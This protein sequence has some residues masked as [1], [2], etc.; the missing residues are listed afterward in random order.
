MKL[1]GHFRNYH[2]GDAAIAPG[3]VPK[4]G[5]TMKHP[6]KTSAVGL[7]L[8]IEAISC[9]AMT[10]G[11]ARGAVV[12][13]QPLDITVPVQ[14]D[15]GEDIFSLCLD[16]DVFYGDAQQAKGRITLTSALPA[17]GQSGTVRVRSSQPVDE[18]V[19]AVSLRAGCPQKVSR[20]FTF[21]ADLPS[22]AV[23]L[24]KITPVPPGPVVT[25]ASAGKTAVI[26]DS[27][28]RRPDT[29]ATPPVVGN[30]K[31]ANTSS[32][33]P[34]PAVKPLVAAAKVMPKL[35]LAS[36]IPGDLRDPDLK[37]TNELFTLPVDN[38]KSAAAAIA[39]WRA[40]N[41]QP[42]DIMRDWQRLQALDADV[43]ALRVATARNESS[44]AEMKQ[45]LQ[46]AESERF[47]NGL[48]YGL[49]GLLLASLAGLFLLW[50]RRKG[51]VGASNS[52]WQGVGASPT[53]QQSG[54]GEIASTRATLSAAGELP[55]QTAFVDIDLDL[56]FA[57][58]AA[59]P[60]KPVPT[61]TDSQVI[62]LERVTS[63]SPPT[64][65]T[66]DRGFST[67]M[68][69][70]L[71]TTNSEEVV[72]VR[73]QADFF[74]SLGQYEQAIHTLMDRTEGAADVSPLVYLDLMQLLHRL[75]RRIDFNQTR[76]KFNRLFTGRVPEYATFDE[77]GKVLE[78]Y[79]EVLAHISSEWSSD[80]ILD[81]LEGCI[82]RVP[83]DDL[84]QPFDLAAFEDLLMLH[85]IATRLASDSH[86]G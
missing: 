58:S 68:V 81:I 85:A 30:A 56:S 5:P 50:R 80:L 26:A 14:T 37:F 4:W 19:V 34:V 23:L 32:A 20:R 59:V 82:F 39:L 13:G 83:E 28:I 16:A 9:S 12:L 27:V 66:T 52:W 29:L 11:R 54:P 64:N 33:R 76:D 78:A 49:V 15:E 69:S 73:Q 42:E 3:A 48:V 40:L 18:P 84:G 67:S 6:V 45:R 36:I 77:K 2:R 75:G 38:P 31:A 70:A 53:Q 71:R 61:L 63:F 57:E 17:N 62:P 35:M 41:A 72:D 24:P 86:K 43:S 47:A 7:L 8:L 25:P 74:V 46:V 44:L 55:T 79:P 21:F 65:W 1:N 60:V 51:E 22:E 10:L